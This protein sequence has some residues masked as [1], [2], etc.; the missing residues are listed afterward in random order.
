MPIQYEAIQ[1]DDYIRIITTGVLKTYEELVE[2]AT[3]IYDQATSTGIPRILLDEEKV[4][5]AVD[6]ETIYVFSMHDI[7]SKTATAGIRIAGICTD[8][9]FECNMGYEV[10]LQK[11]S[12]NFRVFR[13]TGDAIQWLKS[14]LPVSDETTSF[15]HR[16]E[17]EKN[18]IKFTI[19]GGPSSPQEMA[20]YVGYMID[21]AKATGN[22]RL[23]V[24]ETYATIKLDLHQ[25]VVD[26]EVFNQDYINENNIRV[27]VICAPHSLKAYEFFENNIKACPFDLK[28]FDS[29]EDGLKWLEV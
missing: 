18:Y 9:N 7:I 28:V 10:M 27:A 5:E 4:E 21:R 20:S 15:I 26:F 1:E 2:Y 17:V 13:D 11:R 6:V 29:M 3:F 14:N 22:T 24:D 12:Y 25:A 16:M 8:A 19:R 23:L